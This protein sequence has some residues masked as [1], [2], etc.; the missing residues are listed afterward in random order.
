[1]MNKK[2]NKPLTQP[3]YYVLLSLIEK[4]HGYEIM[5]YIEELTNG[6]VKVGPGTLYSMLSRF[7]EDGYIDMVEEIDNK[8]LYKISEIGLDILN[9]EVKR[10]NNLLK[11]YEKVKE[12]LKWLNYNI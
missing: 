10:I 5:T 9:Q 7:E 12:E 8:K 2:I 3:M 1:M 4:R 11:D 6:R